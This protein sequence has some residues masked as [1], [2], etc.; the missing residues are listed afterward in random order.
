[1]IAALRY[2]FP[3]LISEV[4]STRGECI[5]C[6]FEYPLLGYVLG[7]KIQRIPFNHGAGALETIGNCNIQQEIS[8]L[9]GIVVDSIERFRYHHNSPT[10]LGTYLAYNK[11]EMTTNAGFAKDCITLKFHS[12]QYAMQTKESHGI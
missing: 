3:L 8:K 1:M 4:S 9:T 2:Q 5:K 7:Y 11:Y 6:S 12:G 10:S